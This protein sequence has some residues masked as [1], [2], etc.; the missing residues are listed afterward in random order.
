MSAAPEIVPFADEHL[1]GAAALLAERHRR[2]RELEPLLPG[3]YEDTAAARSELEAVWAKE[4]VSGAA[5]HHDGRIAGYLLGAPR[6]ASWG[7]NV[8]VEFAGHAA[9]EAEVVRDLYAVAA[10]RW[11]EEGRTRH[12]ALVPASDAALLES[13]YRLCF[14]QQHA[15][16][17]REV[18]DYEEVVVPDGVEVRAPTAEDVEAL[19]DVDLALPEHQARSPVFSGHGSGTRE[20]LRTEWLSTLAGDEETVLIA[21]LDGRPVA[22]WSLVPVESSRMHTSLARPENAALLGFAS[23][24]PEVRGSGVGLA[25]TAA[26]FA[27]ARESGYAAIVTDWRVTNLLSSRFWPRRGFRTTFLRLYRSIP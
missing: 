6:D 26:S 13:W 10:E 9:E 17:L 20:D 21:T 23:T 7:A 4:G 18:T 19:I 1:D 25:L 11:V 8:W 12:T 2:H 27:W 14:G 16:G 3:R 22:C 24:L 15:H 5:A